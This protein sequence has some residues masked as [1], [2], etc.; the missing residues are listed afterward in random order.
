MEGKMFAP[1]ALTISIA[2]AL[3]LI[4]SFTLS[5]VL[6]SYILKGGADHDTPFVARI[7]APYLKALSWSIS[8]PQ[9]VILYAG[10]ALLFR[11]LVFSLLGKSFIPIMKEGA[12]TPVIVRQANISLEES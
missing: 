11:F 5:P 1:L 12:I 6:C 4:L 8:N 3:S 7:K 10:I 2:L 9:R